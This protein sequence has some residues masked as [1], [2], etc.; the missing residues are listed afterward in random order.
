MNQIALTM[1]TK[2]FGLLKAIATLSACLSILATSHAAS[3][4]YDNTATPIGSFHPLTSESGDQINLAG[5]DRTVTGFAFEYYT[6]LLGG[7]GQATVRFYANDGL[8]G[9]PAS[10]LY[11]SGAFSLQEGSKSVTIQN[12]AVAVPDSFTWTVQ[13]AVAGGQKA[14]LLVYDPPTVGSSVNDF[15]VKNGAEW[16]LNQLN[17]GLTPANFAARVVAVPEP[18]VVALI[19]LGGGALLGLRTTRRNK[20]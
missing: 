4:V 20:A 2:T 17:G 13:F 12:L 3:I 8:Q 1:K 18:G 11:N 14:G 6:E 19:L 5:L 16:D 7:S 9:K 10:E 15:W